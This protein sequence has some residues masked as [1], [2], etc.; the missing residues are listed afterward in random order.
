MREGGNG[1]VEEELVGNY[2]GGVGHGVE[3]LGD[4]ALLVAFPDGILG[5]EG[6]WIIMTVCENVESFDESVVWMDLWSP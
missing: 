6:G 3:E 4:V 2:F 5:Y 1:P